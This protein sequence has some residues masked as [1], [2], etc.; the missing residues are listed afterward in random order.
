MSWRSST[1]W[2]ERV[3]PASPGVAHRCA[4]GD[5]ADELVMPRLIPCPRCYAHVVLDERRCPHCGA[6]LRTTFAP[7]AAT[8]LLLGLAL[9][10]CPGEDPD[11]DSNSS[12]TTTAGTSTSSASGT[13]TVSSSDDSMSGANGVEYG[14]VETGIDDDGTTSTGETSTTGGASTTGDGTGTST[15]TDSTATVGEPEYGVAETSG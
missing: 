1:C 13:G 8:T 12:Q 4:I 7:R 2:S 10:G 11:D 6:E 3:D 14:T 9:A 15:D 5:N